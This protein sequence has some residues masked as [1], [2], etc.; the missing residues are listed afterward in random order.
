[1]A[2]GNDV[3]IRG[4]KRGAQNVVRC[5]CGL[6]RVLAIAGEEDTLVGI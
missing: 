2:F 6:S 3:T 1:M 4:C 5:K